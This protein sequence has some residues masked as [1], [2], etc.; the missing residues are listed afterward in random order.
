MFDWTIVYLFTMG[1]SKSLK[2][3]YLHLKNVFSEFP[4]W[5]MSMRPKKHAW[6][7]RETNDRWDDASVELSI[8]P[9]RRKNE[10]IL[11]AF[12]HYDSNAWRGMC[13]GD[14]ECQE[15]QGEATGDYIDWSL[16]FATPRL[17]G[18]SLWF[19]DQS[20]LSRALTSSPA[21]GLF[22]RWWWF[23]FSK[24]SKSP[25][26]SIFDL[27][28]SDNLLCPI[29]PETPLLPSSCIRYQLHLTKVRKGWDNF[30]GGIL[31]SSRKYDVLGPEA[32]KA[33]G[34]GYHDTGWRG[35]HLPP[36][37]GQWYHCRLPTRTKTVLRSLHP[38]KTPLPAVL[39]AI[40]TFILLYAQLHAIDVIPV[41]VVNA[42]ISFLFASFY[43]PWCWVEE[44]GLNCGG[45]LWKLAHNWHF[46]GVY[47][48]WLP[49]HRMGLENGYLS[50]LTPKVWMRALIL[51]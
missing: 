42:S 24:A 27:S 23:A 5:V 15:N 37:R 9:N 20:L 10:R 8:I 2:K 14:G 38:L 19:R 16:A 28:Q 6:M 7:T 46:P 50:F 18:L 35:L 48:Q 12:S 30:F 33:P 3:S 41:Q 13:P 17:L 36:E 32:A 47:C 1:K 11:I 34:A 31:P 49:G 43:T 25:R 51:Q 45:W 39:F 21:Q 22:F 4:P 29:A 26:V 44:T 40:S